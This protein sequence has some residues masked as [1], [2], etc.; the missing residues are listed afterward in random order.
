[1][2][3]KDNARVIVVLFKKSAGLDVYAVVAGAHS[4]P[5]CV[6]VGHGNRKMLLQFPDCVID[7]RRVG[8]L[9][10]N[11]ETHGETGLIANHGGIDQFEHPV[12]SCRDLPSRGRARKISLTAGGIVSGC[13]A[14]RLIRII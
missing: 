6:F 8:K 7:R 13:L 10:K 4:V 1:M 5:V 9:G 14:H 11:H 3:C 12:H 2:L